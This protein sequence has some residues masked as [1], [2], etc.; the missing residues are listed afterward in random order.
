MS[1]D[2]ELLGAALPGYEIGGEIGRGGWGIVYDATH[3]R[4]GRRVAVKV[5]ARTASA[6]STVREQ[7]IEEARFV[8][9]LDHPHVV[10]VY[11]FVEHHGAFLIVM[12]LLPGG[13]L[14]SRFHTVGVMSD[15][16]CAV[17]LAV[18]TALQMAHAQRRLHRDVKPE[19]VLFGRAGVVK[20]S[21]FGVAKVLGLGS[22][23]DTEVVGTP[24]YMAP[25]HA[26]GAVIG[27]PADVYSAATMLFE[28]LSGRLPFPEAETAAEQVA[29]HARGGPTS[30]GAIADVPD[31]IA[32]VVMGGL[33]TA[34]EDRPGS[35]AA[36]GLQLARAANRSYGPRWLHHSGIELMSAGPITEAAVRDVRSPDRRGAVPQPPRPSTPVPTPRSNAGVSRRTRHSAVALDPRAVTVGPTG[37]VT[38]QRSSA[39]TIARPGAVHP[40]TPPVDT[41]E[42]LRPTTAEPAP[43]SGTSPAGPS[44]GEVVEVVE[45]PGRG[46]GVGGATRPER[47]GDAGAPVGGA[48]RPSGG[49]GEP[50]TGP[51]TGA[52]GTPAGARDGLRQS[53]A[54]PGRED[55]AT[56][57][58]A[59]TDVGSRAD[60][61]R[62]AAGAEDPNGTRATGGEDPARDDHDPDGPAPVRGVDGDAPEGAAGPPAE[63]AGDVDDDLDLDG[64]RDTAGAPTATRATSGPAT[65]TP[66]GPWRPPPPGAPGPLPAPGPAPRE[67]TERSSSRSV[68][69]VA[70]GLI[71]AVAVLVALMMAIGALR[72]DD[73]IEP[74]APEGAAEQLAREGNGAGR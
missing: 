28:M 57:G 74:V 67:R 21:D 14:W 46:D 18:C 59:R 11:D 25:E 6:D 37:G 52:P 62:P 32:E 36:F 26:T 24:V 50:G 31:A 33:A 39:E 40:S 34:P 55:G 41:D 54:D 38:G 23:R 64:G 30:L 8:A 19:N 72:G 22:G 15:E 51:A 61:D 35:A 68:G 66:G 5:L 16:A 29:L 73:G 4:L 44:A 47:G 43:S 63:T 70:I 3:R 69:L 1:D 53:A 49:A 13:T 27:P 42:D 48:T 56:D 58:I 17:T 2:R 12:E 71:A 20:L 10:P 60:A 45:P 7:F 65:A 9:S